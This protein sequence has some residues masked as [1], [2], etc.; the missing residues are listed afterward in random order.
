LILIEHGD[1]L[2]FLPDGAE[3]GRP[4][5]IERLSAMDVEWLA[6]MWDVRPGGRQSNAGSTVFNPAGLELIEERMIH[7]QLP[8]PLPDAAR[9]VVRNNL[10]RKRD[11]YGERLDEGDRAALDALIDEENPQGIMQRDD[12]FLDA[13][14]HVY[15]ARNPAE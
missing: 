1:P 3:I 5:L 8:A 6:T 10:Q 9:Q 7:I 11:L 2:R 13:S 14:R 15:V 12:A 4:G